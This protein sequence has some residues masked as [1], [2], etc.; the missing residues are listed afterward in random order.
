M[1]KKKQE[2]I[3]G[4]ILIVLFGFF[5][6]SS[7]TRRPLEE[8]L[9]T[10]ALIPI[11][12]YW[13]TAGIQPR[14]AT[15]FVYEAATG[16]LF[17]EK[18]FS[19]EK[20]YAYYELPLAPGTYTI[21]LINEIRDQIEHVTIHG[22]NHLSTLEAHVDRATNLYR[23]SPAGLSDIMVEEP[24]ILA[25]S[26]VENFTVTSD[27]IYRSHLIKSQENGFIQS[28]TT[29]FTQ[30]SS[31]NPIDD[32][33]FQLIN[34]YPESKVVDVT[35]KTHVKGLSYALM[36]ALVELR[37]MAEGYSF[38]QDKNTEVPVTCQFLMNNRMY[39]PGSSL[40]GTISGSIR[41]FGVLGERDRVEDTPYNQVLLDFTYKMIDN[42]TQSSFSN[43]VTDLLRIDL[44][45]STIH[46]QLEHAE[47]PEVLDVGGESGLSTEVADWNSEQITIQI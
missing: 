3:I 29:M 11:K 37:N 31:T 7:C 10:K 35:I 27:M 34:L 41:S 36:P 28:Y 39:D 6:I 25:V 46:I 23:A 15:V 43:D 13:H 17:L 32:A 45:Q 26:K 5:S 30:T 38:A 18:S 4:F 14:N 8:E 9:Y 24:G 2:Q 16:N 42:K 33:L 44:P 20:E 40:H 47:L 19:S 21:I 1:Q 22:H 12:A